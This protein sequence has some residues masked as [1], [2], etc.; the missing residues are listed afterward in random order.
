MRY[1][2]AI[3]VWPLFI[4]TGLLS[5]PVAFAATWLVRNSIEIA[6][7]GRRASPGDVLEMANGVWVDQV[8]RFESSGRVGAPITL[9]AQTPGRVVLTGKSRLEIQGRWLVVDGLRFEQGGLNKGDAVVKIGGRQGVAAEDCRLT[10]SS[11]VAYNP[12]DPT[13]RY[14]WVELNGVRL[15]VDHSLF[16]GQN[17]SGPTI[18]VQRNSGAADFALI[19]HNHFLDRIPGASNGHETIRIGTSEHAESP[20]NSIVRFNLFERTN[21][22]MEVISLKAGSNEVRANTFIGVAGT[23]SLRHGSGNVVR[24]NFFD[25]QNLSGTGGVRVSGRDHVVMGNQFQDLDGRLGGIVILHC[26]DQLRRTAGYDRVEDLLVSSNLF[27]RVKVPALR[28]GAGCERP[29]QMAPPDRV[30]V[31]ENILFDAPMPTT[32]AAVSW[33]AVTYADN[34][35]NASGPLADGFKQVLMRAQS[36]KSGVLSV[37]AR[38][39]APDAGG[40]L[41]FRQPIRTKPTEVGPAWR[42]EA[43]VHV[44]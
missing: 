24:D 23:V 34:V 19:E 42:T 33:S 44:R 35:S 17:H 37:S 10:N 12:P 18:V 40:R 27:V 31:V 13:I 1:A 11:I 26:G 7:A 2:S 25:G 16:Q 38:D 5:Q 6:D 4:V 14:P 39:G 36:G 20:S 21:G 28:I 3:V 15:Q 22:E 9:R 30:R 43:S 32:E 29:G 8:V 41:P